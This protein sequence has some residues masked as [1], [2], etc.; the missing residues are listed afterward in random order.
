[1]QGLLDVKGLSVRYEP[2]LHR[3]LTAVEDVTFAIGEGE[4]VGLI[5]E[6]GSGKTTLGMTLLRLL[7]KPGRISAG[8]ITFG[9]I[10]L[11]R[12]SQDELRQYRWRDISTVF[13]S[14]MNALNPVVPI[15]AQFRDVIELHTELRGEA[16]TN[17]VRELFEMVSIEEK[18]IRYYPHELS[19]GMKQR[20]NLALALAN[21]PKFVVLDEPTTGLDVVVQRSI[22]DNVRRLQKEQGFAV[23]F[24]SHDIGTVLDLSDRILVMYA[25]K[26][27]E[28]QPSKRL[29]HDPMHPYSKGLMGSYGDPRAETIRITYVPGR[30]P[31]LS[32]K[33]V[34][35]NFAPRCPERIEIC[36][37]VEPP[38][39]QIETA[40]VACHVAVQQ[41]LGG[42]G[43]V[44]T[45]ASSYPQFVKTATD[46]R[47]ALHGDVLLEAKNIG[48]RFEVRH[49]FRRTSV[50]AVSDVSFVLR[51]SEVTAL[52]GQSGS[53]KTTIARMI[54]GVETLSEG[55]IIFHS[56][57]GEQQVQKFR[58]RALR[59]YRSHVQ[60]VF[61]DPYSS[62]NP[63]HTLE[64]ILTRP[65]RNYAKLSKRQARDRAAELL[66][67]VALTPA[68]RFLGRYAYELSGGQRQRVVIARA[69]APKPELIVADEP[70]S[71]LD[72]SIRAEILLLL[73]KLVQESD[74]AILYITHDLLSARMLSD[75]TIVL[76]QGRVVEHGPSLRV[77]REPDDPYTRKLLEAVPN[78]FHERL[79]RDLADDARTPSPPPSVA[80]S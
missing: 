45:A 33:R 35:C 37:R 49:G 21:R 64:Y 15:E 20:I 67:T 16:V 54:T 47:K 51:K 26:V 34:G 58:G 7:E 75:E 68:G 6:S 48:R 19:G 31:D 9:G 25:G 63:A 46:S 50:N 5:G 24:I 70:V 69:L 44:Q 42:K 52:V 62:L 39:T 41:R 11:T 18:F 28:E 10:D 66:E 3:P 59:S 23:L 77:I 4:F 32:R 12:L 61:Q 38:L 57:D 78:P 79:V 22:L 73:N 53:G 13:Q 72:V 27:V 17:H 36:Q 40:R 71:S 43:E 74:V 65:L 30:P 1:M 76:Y 56:R 29:M 80:S 55:S 14:S 60:M 8:S 2:K